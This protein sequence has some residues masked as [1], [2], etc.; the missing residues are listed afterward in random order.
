MR[1]NIMKEE[2]KDDEGRKKG[3]RVIICACKQNNNVLLIKLAKQIRGRRWQTANPMDMDEWRSFHFQH[4]AAMEEEHYSG[5][6][7]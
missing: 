6:K 1:W 4:P 3:I 7:K 5:K 2:Q